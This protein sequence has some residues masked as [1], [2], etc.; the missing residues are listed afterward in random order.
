MGEEGQTG[1]RPAIGRLANAMVAVL[2]PELRVGSDHYNRC[3]AIIRDM[4]VRIYTW[5]VGPSWP[6]ID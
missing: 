4:Q 2:G 3:R 1:L 5:V 6:V